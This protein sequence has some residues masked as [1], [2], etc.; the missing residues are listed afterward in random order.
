MGNKE[1]VRCDPKLKLTEGAA[2]INKAV[3][4]NVCKTVSSGGK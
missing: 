2:R 3:T 1:K 4:A